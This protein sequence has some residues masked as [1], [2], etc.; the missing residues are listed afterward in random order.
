MDWLSVLAKSFWPATVIFL[1]LYFNKDISDLLKKLKRIGYSG[2]EFESPPQDEN[3]VNESIKEVSETSVRQD[4][5]PVFY[6][7]QTEILTRLKSKLGNDERVKNFCQENY[8]ILFLNYTFFKI[9]KVIF[10]T[11]VELLAYLASI[12]QV[13]SEQLREFYLRGIDFYSNI[14]FDSYISFLE[15]NNLITEQNDCFQITPL[16]RDFLKYLNFEKL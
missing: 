13:N 9:Y 14:T 3:I 12:H 11:Q 4:D 1:A 15:S 5:T 7:T 10:K 6:E 2:A 16:G 8:P